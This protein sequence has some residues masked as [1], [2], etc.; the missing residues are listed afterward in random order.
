MVF[1]SIHRNSSV[2]ESVFSSFAQYSI[3]PKF[4][5]IL[6][7]HT[8][9]CFTLPDPLSPETFFVFEMKSRFFVVHPMTS[10]FS[11]LTNFQDV[12]MLFEGN[13]GLLPNLDKKSDHDTGGQW[14]MAAFT[15]RGRCLLQFCSIWIICI[16]CQRK[17]WIGHTSPL[18]MSL[19]SLLAL[20]LVPHGPPFCLTCCGPPFR[21]QNTLRESLPPPLPFAST[22]TPEVGPWVCLAESGPSKR[23]GR[24]EV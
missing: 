3:T 15:N 5:F 21:M 23:H 6:T 14:A 16:I 8:F 7:C 20:N 11:Q 13:P 4:I 17:L 9:L 12:R 19:A 10:F 1:A 2:L 24:G 18:T 22:C